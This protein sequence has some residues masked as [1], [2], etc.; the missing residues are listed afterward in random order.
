MTEDKLTIMFEKF[1]KISSLKLFKR[2]DGFTYSHITYEKIE[3]AQAAIK[4]MNKVKIEDKR[5]KVNFA[6]YVH[7]KP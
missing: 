4:A 5:L 1:G 3:Q 2:N 6:S 7:K